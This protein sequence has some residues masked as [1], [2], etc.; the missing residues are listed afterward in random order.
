MRQARGGI[1]KAV[2]TL[3]IVAMAISGVRVLPSSVLL[4]TSPSKVVY[5]DPQG[6]S[7]GPGA[8]VFNPS[9][10]ESY[11]PEYFDLTSFSVEIDSN[12]VRFSIGLRAIAN[13]LNSPLGFSPQVV[14]IY[15]VGECSTRRSDTL[16]LNVRLR[17]ADS[18]CASVVITPNLG[19]YNSR[20]VLANGTEIELKKI[21]V[22]ENNTIVAEVPSEHLLDIVKGNVEKWRFFVAVTAYD[23]KSPDGLIDV[24]LP[25]SNASVIY[26]GTELPNPTLLPRILDILT[27]RVEDQYAMLGAYPLLRG[28]I[29]TVAAYPYLEKLLLPFEFVTRVEFIT[30]TSFATTTYLKVYEVPGVTTTTT[31]YVQVPKYG[32]ELYV[33]ALVCVALVV[34]L[35]YGLRKFK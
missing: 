33:L 15:I 35:A 2:V 22:A 29:A 12:V 31:Q 30:T 8:Y 28:D 27:D 19:N 21:Y 10:T 1:H 23:P 11:K 14:H 3:L 18:W 20:V 6:D 34:V 13:P 9:L 16:G 26:N 32:M 25:G 4:A 24:G 5:T 17:S 7:F